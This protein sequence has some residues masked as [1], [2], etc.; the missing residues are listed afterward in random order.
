MEKYLY[1]IIEFFSIIIP[2]IYTFHSRLNFHKNFPSF[3][4]GFLLMFFVFI[5]WDIW[6]TDIGIWG[7]N[8]RYLSGLFLF[9][10]PIEEY[11]FFFIIPYACIFTYHVVYTLSKPTSFNSN[12][13]IYV[14]SGLLLVIGV[15]YLEKR[16][17][18]I[19]FISLSFLLVISKRFVNMTLFFKTFLFILIP[20]I[21]VNGLLTGSFIEEQVVWYN[22]D[23]NLGIRLGTIPIEDVFY[24]MEML[25]LVSLFYQS[26]LRLK[27]FMRLNKT[28]AKDAPESGAMM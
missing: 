6:F 20:F 1:L 23:Y 24:G 22:D 12:I 25:L 9:G 2:L 21:I 17:T 4:L 11:M 5:P 19:T 10:L 14:L 3:L 28:V 15:L 8:E 7:F 18:S 16:Y 13:I 27:S 26:N